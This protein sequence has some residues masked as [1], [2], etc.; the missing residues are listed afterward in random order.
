ME[1]SYKKV[2]KFMESMRSWILLLMGFALLLLALVSCTNQGEVKTGPGGEIEPGTLRLYPANPGYLEYRGEPV[3]LITS[4]EHYGA[5][6]NLDFDYRTYLETLEAEGFNYTRVFSG[7][8]IEPVNNIFGIEKNT[9]APL[10][11]RFISPW[12][13]ENG[14]YDLDRF[15]PE[16]FDRLKDFMDEAATRDII[17]EVT[18]FTSIYAGNAWELCPFNAVNNSNG[19]GDLDFRRV[20]TL[21]N[22]NLRQYQEQFIRK[23][24]KE[25][26]SYD[27]LFFEIQ[28][29]PW[30]DNSNLSA[31]LD[32][33][34]EEFDRAN[35]QRR[36]ETANG[37]SLEWQ[38]WVASVIGDEESVAPKK[39]LLAQNI[40]NFQHD[41]K[42]LPEGISLI[43][44]HYALPDAA[45]LN[46]GIGGV[47]G[48][49]ETGF[50]PHEDHL[51]INQAWRFILSGGGT[52]NNLD[53]SFTAGNETGRWPIPGHN[54]GWGGPVFR[55]K[56]SY[57]AETMK[58]VP[59]YE[60][61]PSTSI[62][63]P[64]DETMKQYGL[65]KEGEHYLVFLERYK[66]VKLVPRV[67]EANYM[68][69]W[70]DVETGEQKSEQAE[71]DGTTAISAP[72][73]KE[74][75]VLLIQLTDKNLN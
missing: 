70:L 7:T 30:S 32:Q 59:F 8:Y 12:V 1:Q 15:N 5:V 65:Q 56:L 17:V 51:Y 69:T 63:D 22:G 48:L 23:M 66:G 13:S 39:H 40:S 52:Y 20:N 50:M 21:Y 60:M 33:G 9:L 4:A 73:E 53:Y 28:N 44:F 38:A 37:V 45:L 71:L 49:D 62:L 24:V 47:T 18:L 46:R 11:G 64:A 74:Q 43:N 19:V 55:K 3:I 58:R 29:E 36:V 27:N 16:Y 35:W 68:V 72:F 54:P 67:T 41:Q 14:R 10:E 25:L 26:N 31:Y 6:V 61:K 57:L 34:E 42:V 75:V 2:K